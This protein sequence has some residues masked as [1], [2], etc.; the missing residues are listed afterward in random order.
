MIVK[1]ALL[2]QKWRESA[3]IVSPHEAAVTRDIRRENG[4]GQPTFDAFRGQSDDSR[5][6]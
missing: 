4:G 2:Y 1:F 6:G 3:F 5:T